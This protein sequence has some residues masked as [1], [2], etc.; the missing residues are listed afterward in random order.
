MQVQ[1]RE[2]ATRR[3]AGVS[4]LVEAITS[5]LTPAVRREKSVLRSSPEKLVE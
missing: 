5:R 2:V 4:R 1:C 3:T